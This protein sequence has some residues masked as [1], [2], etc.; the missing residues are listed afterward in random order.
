M[1]YVQ[2]TYQSSILATECEV[3]IVMIKTLCIQISKTKG[4]FEEWRRTTVVQKVK[5]LLRRWRS[6]IGQV[7]IKTMSTDGKILKIGQR[8]ERNWGFWFNF[9]F[10]KPWVLFDGLILSFIQMAFSN[11]L[12]YSNQFWI[13]FA[14]LWNIKSILQEFF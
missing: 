2:N 13:G 10:K 9:D 4:R 12:Q 5:S 14:L 3:T 7:S 1:I 6:K 8:V 11:I